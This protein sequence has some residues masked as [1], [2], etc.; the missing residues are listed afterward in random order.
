[1][2]ANTTGYLKPFKVV[3]LVLKVVTVLAVVVRRIVACGVA[4]VHGVVAELYDEL[5]VLLGIAS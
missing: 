5:V 1:M 3:I 2:A 4:R